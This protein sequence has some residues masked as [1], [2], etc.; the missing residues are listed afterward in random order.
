MI[1]VKLNMMSAW[2]DLP[3]GPW[4][5]CQRIHLC[6]FQGI[7][8]FLSSHV[9]HSHCPFCR[10]LTVVG[11]PENHCWIS[12]IYVSQ[13]VAVRMEI[14]LCVQNMVVSSEFSFVSHTL[15]P[16]TP[17]LTL[18]FV[19]T[20]SGIGIFIVSVNLCSF[21]KCMNPRKSCLFYEGL[22]WFG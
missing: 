13:R 18:S 1:W 6:F 22:I 8:N 21:S 17:V 15:L 2:S 7:Q 20:L 12:D 4:T 11:G 19:T 10:V 16:R 3:I 9:E 5:F 14:G